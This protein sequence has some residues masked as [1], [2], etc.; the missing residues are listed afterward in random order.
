MYGRQRWLANVHHT[1]SR[2]LLNFLARRA[3]SVSDRKVLLSCLTLSVF[4]YRMLVSF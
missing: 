3:S 4:V 1:L 2:D